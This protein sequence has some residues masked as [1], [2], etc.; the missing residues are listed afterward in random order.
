MFLL[1]VALS[2]IGV[3][4]DTLFHWS[5][6]FWLAGII[7]C[8]F[9]LRL[10]HCCKSCVNSSS[11]NDQLTQDRLMRRLST[12]IAMIDLDEECARYCE[13]RAAQQQRR[14]PS[15]ICSSQSRRIR[16]LSGGARRSV[17]RCSGAVAARLDAS[18]SSLPK[19]EDVVVIEVPDS[20]TD[21]NQRTEQRLS[22][23]EADPPPPS[24][25]EVVARLGRRERREDDDDQVPLM[26]PTSEQ[27]Q[28]VVME[29]LLPPTTP[30]STSS[31]TSQQ[32]QL[33]HQHQQSHSSPDLASISVQQSHLS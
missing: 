20:G 8:G 19:Y 28:G 24:Y 7:A 30:P 13:M 12:G 11:S 9:A 33:L 3:T 18:V 17:H 5:P 15:R 23:P 32:Q 21:T 10:M 29:S 1:I 27:S 2:K 16:R 22:E 4:A 6:I 31:T 26:A 25:D 14:V